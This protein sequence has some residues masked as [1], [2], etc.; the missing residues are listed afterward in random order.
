MSGW[1]S[2]YNNSRLALA[3]QSNLMAK[4]QEQV[5]SGA[6]V[7]RASDAPVDAFRVM[8][9]RAQADYAIDYD[10]NIS[11]VSR[12]QE[13]GYDVVQNLSQTIQDVLAK[14]EQ[15]ASDTYNSN[16]RQIIAQGVD[17]ALQ[18]A[19]MLV[20]TRSLGRY[21]IGGDR[22]DVQPYTAQSDGELV[23]GVTYQGGSDELMVPVAVNL[24][25]P[26]TLAGQRMLSLHDRQPATF[27]GQTGAAAGS[28][29]NSVTGNVLLTVAHSETVIVADAD[30]TGLTVSAATA[31]TDTA[32]GRMEVTVDVPN[33]RIKIDGGDWVSFSGDETALAVSTAEGKTVHLD[34]SH[35]SALGAA[36]T[37]TIQSNGTLSIGDGPKTALNDFTQQNVAVTDSAGHVMYVNA[38]GIRQSGSELVTNAGTDDLFSTLIYARDVLMERI[39]VPGVPPGQL[40]AQAVETLRGILDGV[41]R[42][43]TTTGSR[44]QA[45]DTLQ[46]SM[47]SVRDIANDQ[48]AKIESSDITDLTVQLA[49]TQTLYEM[50]LQT[51]AKLLQLNLLD[52]IK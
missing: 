50:T 41:T 52:F 27:T 46:T 39:Q 47:T 38:T 11:E 4:L 22:T 24:D 44:L 13:A 43:M 35:L 36:A 29:T 6:R 1:G 25:M 3:Q 48:A 20:N 23:T 32:L 33:S 5:S 9:L 34:V 31:G 18:Q 28:G 10:T 37:V 26:G 51:A 2:I 30:G 12:I 42:A 17:A 45:L 40:I 8:Q 21:I 49:R 14:L 7:N 19:L 16:S 15:V